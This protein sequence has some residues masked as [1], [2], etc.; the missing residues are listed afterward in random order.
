MQKNFVWERR[1]FLSDFV[2]DYIIIML[3]K[4]NQYFD[5]SAQI[6]IIKAKLSKLIIIELTFLFFFM[7]SDLQFFKSNV[8][9]I[10]SQGGTTCWNIFTMILERCIF[11]ILAKFQHNYS[12]MDMIKRKQIDKPTYFDWN[13]CWRKFH[14]KLNWT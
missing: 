5:C 2:V 7:K 6:H 3:I 8:Q 14:D 10:H 11:A 1:F 4:V 9:K 12:I 13:S